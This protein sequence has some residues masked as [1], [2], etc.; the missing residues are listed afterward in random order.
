[1]YNP[2]VFSSINAQN[3]IKFTDEL[4]LEAIVQSHG[5]SCF[6]FCYSVAQEFSSLVHVSH[7]LPAT[8][9]QADRLTQF[10]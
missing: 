9:E 6:L 7:Q 10:F 2:W 8:V 4:N 3:V 5:E 1:M